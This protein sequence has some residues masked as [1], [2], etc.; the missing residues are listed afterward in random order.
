MGVELCIE[1]SLLI[2]H[3]LT[4]KVQPVVGVVV[5]VVLFSVVG[6]KTYETKQ[7]EKET[8]LITINN[9]D[10]KIENLASDRIDCIEKIS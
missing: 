6:S 7:K 9:N 2:P 4:A 5:T 1:F 3:L 8:A 10:T